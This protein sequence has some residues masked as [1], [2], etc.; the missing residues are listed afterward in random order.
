MGLTPI[1]IMSAALLPIFRPL[2]VA[3]DW[4]EFNPYFFVNI[5]S[6]LKGDVHFSEFWKQEFQV[7]RETVDPDFVKHPRLLG[8]FPKFVKWYFAKYTTAKFCESRNVD[9]FRFGTP[10]KKETGL[11]QTGLF[12]VNKYGRSSSSSSSS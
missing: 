8:W 12:S 10:V 11:K 3:H 2:P 1:E 9:I 6:Y 4:V 7:V 5:M